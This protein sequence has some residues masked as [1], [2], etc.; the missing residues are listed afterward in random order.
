MN[1]TQNNDT[2]LIENYCSDLMLKPIN[3]EPLSKIQ[4]LEKFVSKQ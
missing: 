3:L 4:F 1:K 2:V